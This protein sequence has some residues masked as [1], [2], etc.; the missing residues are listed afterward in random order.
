MNLWRNKHIG[1][2]K[3]EIL[4]LEEERKRDEEERKRK[5]KELLERKKKLIE[6]R[7]K[8]EMR[9]I[10]RME[11]QETDQEK[12]AIGSVYNTRFV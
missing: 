7:R 6:D 4:R 2:V 11:T 10:K 8:L 1:K 5:R 9:K 12:S 3:D